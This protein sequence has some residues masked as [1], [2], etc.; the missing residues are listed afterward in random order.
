[1]VIIFCHSFIHSFIYSSVATLSW[2]GLIW[3]E[4]ECIPETPGMEQKNA[5][6]IECQSIAWHHVHTFT[7]WSNYSSHSTSL[8]VFV[9]WKKT[10][11]PRGNPWAW[12]N[13]WISI[14]T[15]IWRSGSNTG[16]W[17]CTH[18]CLCSLAFY[19]FCG[20]GFVFFIFLTAN[21]HKHNKSVSVYS[22]HVWK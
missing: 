9:R 7:S 12:E 17:R 20:F 11:E 4:S 3:Y 18:N 21:L 6:R 10:G 14:Q 15:V 22:K 1:M 16:H 5:L 2:S 19:W 13:M 8:N